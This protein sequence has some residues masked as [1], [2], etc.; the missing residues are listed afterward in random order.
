MTPN[1]IRIVMVETSHPGNIGACARAMKNMCLDQLYLV[2]PR[3]FPDLEAYSR[4]AGANDVLDKATVCTSL[5]EALAD[6]DLVVGASARRRSIPWPELDPRQCAEKIVNEDE[7]TQAAIVFGRERTGLENEELD[8]CHYLLHIPCNPEYSSLNV[9]AAVQVVTYELMMQSQATRQPPLNRRS[10]REAPATNQEMEAL[11]EHMQQTLYD[12]E[13]INPEN[14]GF[15]MRRLRRL[16]GRAGVEKTE[17]NILRGIL[18]AAQIAK[19]GRQP[20]K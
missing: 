4:S 8:L 18:T 16:L 17:M 2:N 15:M 11:F 14:P 10:K 13:F 20:K 3:S 19:H 12:I 6:C 1:Q 7:L 5:A 9:A